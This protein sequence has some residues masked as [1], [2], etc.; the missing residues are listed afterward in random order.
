MGEKIAIIIIS[1]LS[2]ILVYLTSAKITLEISKEF[3]RSSRIRKILTVIS[4]I[5]IINF[6]LITIYGIILIFIITGKV[7][8]DIIIDIKKGLKKDE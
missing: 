5:P 4:V 8:E 6:I 1:I 3:E 7:C 2:S